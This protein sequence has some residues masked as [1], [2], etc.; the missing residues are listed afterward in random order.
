MPKTIHRHE[1]D[2]LRQLLRERRVNQGLTQADCAKALH[3]NQ[4]FISD[5]ER[6][7]KRLDVIELRDLCQVLNTNY[8]KFLGEFERLLLREHR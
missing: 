2:L 8:V 3:H 7:S 4:S 5:V 6:G 1:Y